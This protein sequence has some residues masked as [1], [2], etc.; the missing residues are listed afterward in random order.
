MTSW[1]EF[2]TA[3]PDI[4]AEGR[5]LIYARGDGEALLATVRNDDLPRIHPVNVAIVDD[6]LYV[7]VIAG[8]PETDRPRARRPIRAPH[9]PG[10]GRPERRRPRSRPSRGRSWRAGARRRRTGRS[11]IDDGY[12]LFELAME[13]RCLACERPRTTGR[14]SIR[15]GARGRRAGR[16]PLGPPPRASSRQGDE[17]GDPRAQPVRVLGVVVDR[18]LVDPPG[19]FFGRFAEASPRLQHQSSDRHWPGSKRSPRAGPASPRGRG[20]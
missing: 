7:F 19:G 5:R 15:R 14:R 16:R 6:R 17:L 4:A 18:G 11:R 20:R 2:A 9:A 8:S 12:I 10:S 13:T 3:A 1:G